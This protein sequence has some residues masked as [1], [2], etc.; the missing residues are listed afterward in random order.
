[1]FLLCPLRG[2]FVAALF[3]LTHSTKNVVILVSLPFNSGLPIDIVLNGPAFDLA[4]EMVNR[5]Y[6]DH[7][8]V[9]MEYFYNASHRTCDEVAAPMADRIAQYYY[10]N[11][12]PTTC[13]AV[14]STNCNDVT[15]ITSLVKSYDWV[16]F[17]NVYVTNL[18]WG[19]SL[20][21]RKSMPA[22]A[23]G[24]THL[25]YT[26]AVLDVLVRYGWYHFTV[27][28]EPQGALPFYRDTAAALLQNVRSAP[29]DQPFAMQLFTIE[30]LSD[31]IILRLL[32][33][34]KQT[35]RVLIISA[36]GATAR[37][38]MN[39][40]DAAGIATGEYIFM[41]LQSS[42]KDN[43]MFGTIK[44]FSVSSP[45]D[46]ANLKAFR[47]L[48]YIVYRKAGHELADLNAEIVKRT[49]QSYNFTYD[50]AMDQP[51]D[52]FSS[53][54]SYNMVEP[55]AIV[56]N[57]S[58]IADRCSGMEL[59]NRMANRTFDISTGKLRITADKAHENDLNIFGFNYSTKQLQEIGKFE[60]TTNLWTWDADRAVA[61]PTEDHKPPPD[62]PP[63]G[64]SGI[65]G[66]CGTRIKVTASAI[67]VAII[68]ILLFGL[69]LFSRWYVIGSRPIENWWRI[70]E[71]L[72]SQAVMHLQRK[73]SRALSH[74]ISSTYSNIGYTRHD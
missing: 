26:R 7:V 57:E 18:F 68:F 37:S 22:V 70:D 60:W 21:D 53:K 51:M 3:T 62:I 42:Q 40:A 30:K 65:D 28:V 47:A 46:D 72:L 49:K 71:H 29:A 35:S 4:S 43:R 13:Y 8:R 52:S 41:V 14:V 39:M 16:T 25:G 10:R 69:A 27:L 67:P 11:T 33:T 2:I 36:I 1:M 24:A 32:Q 73:S 12:T 50:A 15:G 59:A 34:A 17:S 54:S 74:V 19:P 61:W 55:L 38:I 64:F 6:G 56:V 44:Q 58:H 63:C 9:K 66:Q 48:L 20:Q 31:A 23:M 5:K 45:A